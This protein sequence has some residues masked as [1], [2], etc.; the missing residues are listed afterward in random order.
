[1]GGPT[2][3]HNRRI[4]QA[5]LIDE[6]RIEELISPRPEWTAQPLS[7]RDSEAHLGSVDEVVRQGLA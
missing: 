4:E 3:I 6:R 7:N 1:M 2:S 5:L